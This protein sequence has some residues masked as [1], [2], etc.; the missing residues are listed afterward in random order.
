MEERWLFHRFWIRTVGCQK[1]K[2][3]L[4]YQLHKAM[5]QRSSLIRI[6]GEELKTVVQPFQTGVRGDSGVI[7][8]VDVLAKIYPKLL[9]S[10]L[11]GKELKN[12]K[13]HAR[14]DRNISQIKNAG[15][16][17]PQLYI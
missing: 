4:A 12:D 14:D 7:L 10:I 11:P 17:N 1:G 2:L 13:K 8:F 9:R 15:L 16:K 6:I 3:V 5:P